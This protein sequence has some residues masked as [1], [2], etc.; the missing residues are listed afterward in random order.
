MLDIATLRAK[1]GS[2]AGVLT[3]RSRRM[4]AATEARALG[5]GGIALVERAT[6]I[7]RS[8]IARGIHELQ[9]AEPLAPD[10][11]RRA[12]GGRKRAAE[13]V[14]LLRRISR[15]LGSI[16]SA[17][18]FTATGST[19]FIR[20]PHHHRRQLFSDA[21]LGPVALEWGEFCKG[22]SSASR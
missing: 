21:S 8:T 16:L 13:K 20:R 15:W 12:G 9:E 6:G 18:R 3:E 17:T 22:S 4:W 5:H 1:Y 2:L 11:T 7:S 19:Q 14:A 10:R